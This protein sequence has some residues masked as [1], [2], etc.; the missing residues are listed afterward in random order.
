MKP[1]RWL[2]LLVAAAIPPACRWDSDEWVHLTVHN[3]G[4]ASADVRAEAEY[5]ARHFWEDHA[6][7]SLHSGQSVELRFQLDNLTRLQVRV[8]RATDH[9]MILDEEWSHAE[10]HD[11]GRHLT[12]SVSP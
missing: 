3:T 6:D 8:Y 5:W 1:L 12:V 11:L 4:T 10:L 2:L 7:V 9:L